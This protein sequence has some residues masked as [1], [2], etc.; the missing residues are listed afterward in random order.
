MDDLRIECQLSERPI[1]ATALRA[2]LPHL[3]ACGGYVAFEG[4][5][6]NHNDGRRVLRMEYEVY[7]ALALRELQ[8]I[9]ETAA[10]RHGA[11]F[12][13]VVHRKGQ[14]EIGETAVLIQVLTAHRAEAF[15]ACREIIDTLKAKVPIWKRETYD[16]G[17][18]AWP[19][20]QDHEHRHGASHHQHAHGCSEHHD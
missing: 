9:A 10:K 13:R 19:R 4:L 1:D 5:I 7:E 6:R 14:V 3:P 15:A 18:H 11:A 16:D 2:S 20:C 17:S 12:V 8:R